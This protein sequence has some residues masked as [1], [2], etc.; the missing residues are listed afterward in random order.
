ML[1]V[2]DL[3]LGQSRA[4]DDRPHHR[5]RAAIQ[6]PA[7]SKLHQL[8]GDD[9]FG[10]IRHRGVV[11]F[12]VALD[13]EA[14][15]LGHLDADPL[16]GK[17]PALAPEL[18]DRNAVLALALGAVLLLDLPFDWK[19]MAVPARHIIGVVAHH[20]LRANDSVLEDLVQACADVQIA[21][22]VR[23]P[24]MQ[25]EF[26]APLGRFPQELVQVHLRPAVEQLR[27]ELRQ[28]RLHP[29]SG[30]RQKQRLR[31]VALG[32]L[33]RFGRRLLFS[34]ELCRGRFMTRIMVIFRMTASLCAARRVIR[35]VHEISLHC[36]LRADR[37]K[38][39]VGIGRK[40]HARKVAWR[41]LSAKFPRMALP[42]GT[43]CRL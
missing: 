27:L 3:G 4:L 31:P 18:V 39:A 26:L 41:K 12:P 16:L 5:L 36:A 22:R 6:K 11:M 35:F 42:D 17:L 32:T 29:E 10:L 21:V 28:A 13:A 37:L 25:N 2:L 23:R 34:L 40:R 19:A 1:V 7:H 24:I 15:E 43:P 9:G 8:V 14:A 38:I 30:F 33:C 20:L